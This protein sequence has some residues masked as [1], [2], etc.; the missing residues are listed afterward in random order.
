[1]KKLSAILLACLLLVTAFSCGSRE[2]SGTETGAAAGNAGTEAAE[3][4]AETSSPFVADDLPDTLKFDGRTATFYIGDYMNA[5]WDDFYAETYNGVRLNDT[6]YDA[7]QTVNTRL[8]VSM[9]HIQDS[10]NWP[11]DQHRQRVTSSILAGDN[12]FDVLFSVTNFAAEQ[13]TS[14]YFLN[15]A[16]VPHIDLSKPWYNQSIPKVLPTGDVWFIIGDAGLGNVKHTF[17]VFFNQDLFAS[18]GIDADPYALVDGG[19][20]TLDAF[21]SIAKQAY[22]DVNGDATKDPGDNYGLTLGDNNKLLGFYSALGVTIFSTSD[23]GFT[24]EYG[25]ERAV[26]VV[27]KLCALLH[28]NEGTAPSFPNNADHPDW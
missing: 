26:E 19:K 11:T 14:P 18:F 2:E 6:I 9:K 23:S 22:N 1:M 27:Q 17:C 28:E 4:E 20:W 3:T 21:T 5:F 8:D 16:G 10:F 15:L 12:S 24:I 13:I 7:I 25:S